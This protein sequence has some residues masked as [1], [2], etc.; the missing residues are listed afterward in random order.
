MGGNILRGTIAILVLGIVGIL[1]Y[2]GYTKYIQKENWE[3]LEDSKIEVT[4]D[5][6]GDN[7]AGYWIIHSPEMR[8]QCMR[9]GIGINFIPEILDYAER[10]EIFRKGAACVTEPVN[11]FIEHGRKDNYPGVSPAIISESKGADLVVANTNVLPTGTIED[12]NDASLRIAYT[13]ASPSS[14]LLD[15]VIE[16]FDLYELK[17]SNAWRVEADGSEDARKMLMEGKVDVAV[18][19][20]PDGQK[21]LEDPRFAEVVSSAQFG[22]H[23]VDW[24]V[25]N[26]D[27]LSKDKNYDAAKRFLK[28]YFRVLTIYANNQERMAEEMAQSKIL[29]INRKQAEYIMT[30]IDWFDLEENAYHQMGIDNRDDDI[31]Y[32]IIQCTDVMIQ[33]GTLKEDP[34][35]GDPYQLI[36]TR[37]IEE[38]V[39]ETRTDP[40]KSTIRKKIDFTPKTA[41]EWQSLREFG[42]LKTDP[43]TF[44]RGR[45]VLTNYPGGGEDAVHKAIELLE[46]SFTQYRVLVRGH[47]GGKNNQ[48]NMELSTE[49]ADAV[50]QYMISQGMDPDRI[51][52][53]GVG[54]TVPPKRRPGEDERAY[55]IR[56]ARVEFILY[57]ENTL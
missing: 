4:I 41:S 43:V 44:D 15:I 23:I 33:A 54:S 57:E 38:L 8:K 13:P 2:Y 56:E 11:S 3:D 27:W 52:S 51:L 12:L 49:R 21:A 46:N 42:A 1:S 29:D 5:I 31:I 35:D 34:L 39:S 9:Q 7:Y 6:Y 30:R 24:F 55:R 26:K 47:T 28:T 22:K 36:H 20:E 17:A 45:T 32:T 40:G 10:E 25:F 48:K 16:R 18:I 19:W 14:F 53:E 50:R 37:M